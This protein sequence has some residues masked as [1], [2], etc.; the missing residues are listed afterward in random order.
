MRAVVGAVIALVTLSIPQMALASGS[1][2]QPGVHVDPGSPAGKEYQI[3]VVGARTEAAGGTQGQ[4]GSPPLFGVGVTPSGASATSATSATSGA[5]QPASAASGP[6]SGSSSATRT[7][8]ARPHP[9]THTLASSSPSANDPLS[10]V[11]SRA[12]GT[13]GSPAAGGSGWIALV[14]GGL[15]VLVLGGGGGLLL[16]QRV[17]RS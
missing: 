2:L 13:S 14:A 1:T 3:P 17:L 7:A 4:G 11:A 16:R 10:A 8:G 5:G 6:P 15:L 9:R 12:P